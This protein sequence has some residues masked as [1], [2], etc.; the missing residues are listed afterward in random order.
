MM[1][2][3]ATSNVSSSNGKR[4]TVPTWNAAGRHRRRAFARAGDLL[5]PWIDSYDTSVGAY[6]RLRDQSKSASAT[7]HVKHLVARTEG[8]EVGRPLAQLMQLAMEQATVKDPFQEV[9][10]PAHVQNEPARRP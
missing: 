4:S 8:R 9:I 1:V 2:L 10:A 3:S 5:G 6:P 7:A